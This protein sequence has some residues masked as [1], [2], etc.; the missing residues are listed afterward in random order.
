MEVGYCPTCSAMWPRCR[1]CYAGPASP[2]PS[3]G[4]EC[5]SV[6][7]K[8]AFWWSSPDGS[9]V[10]AEY[11]AAGYSTGA[12]LGD[13]AK[14]L[15]RRIEAFEER[16]LVL[17]RAGRSNPVPERRRSSRASAVAR[18]VVAEANAIQDHFEI[19]IS[20]LPEALAGAPRAG[21][22]TWQGELRS[23]ARAKP[24]DGRRID[25]VDVKQSAHAPNEPSSGSLKPMAASL[26]PPEQYP[27]AVL[28]IAWARARAQRRSRLDLR[29]LARRGRIRSA[30]PLRGGDAHSRGR[31]PACSCSPRLVVVATLPRRG[32]PVLE[33]RSG[34][35]EMIIGG[36]GPIE[37]PRSSTSGSGWQPTRAYHH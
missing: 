12:S 18:P 14:A 28:E 1:S 4:A 17:D 7:D 29:L 21:L 16:T 37:G 15:I 27:E 20:S 8:T 33:A 10:R 36:Q 25:R 24:V 34:V 23:S 2:M 26:M 11:I 19:V 35:V 5:P 22:P 32:E 6:V 13:D 31:D 3:S 9:V 30:P